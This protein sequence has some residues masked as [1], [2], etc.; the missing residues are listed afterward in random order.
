MMC[1]ARTRRICIFSEHYATVILDNVP[2]NLKSS[3]TFADA[4]KEAVVHLT[5]F[6][7]LADDTGTTAFIRWSSQ[8]IANI[9]IP[10]LPTREETR[11]TCHDGSVDSGQAA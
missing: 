2:D 4:F 1:V 8:N 7:K 6:T 11:R 3:T 5:H 9:P 10:V